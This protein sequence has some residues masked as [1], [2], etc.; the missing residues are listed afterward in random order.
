MCLIRWLWNSVAILLAMV[1]AFY[2]FYIGY[3]NNVFSPHIILYHARDAGL[4]KLTFISH[5]SNIYSKYIDDQAFFDW[6]IHWSIIIFLNPLLN[7]VLLYYFL[8][9]KCIIIEFRTFN[10]LR[11]FLTNT[12]L[13]LLRPNNLMKEKMHWSNA[14]QSFTITSEKQKTWSVK[15][16]WH[17]IT[18][19]QFFLK[20]H[21]FWFFPFH[22]IQFN[23]NYKV[24]M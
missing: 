10:Q 19:S 3:S 5:L 23:I 24:N 4:E 17:H 20:I 21:N 9:I 2:G 8:A 11:F 16:N 7:A 15:K 14:I 6:N 1:R 18:C 22:L 13:W 12:H